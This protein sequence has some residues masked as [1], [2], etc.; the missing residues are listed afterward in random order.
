MSYEFLITSA[1][2]L[3]KTLTRAY[4]HTEKVADER[5]T[6][7]NGHGTNP[8]PAP[9]AAPRS[10]ALDQELAVRRQP[11]GQASACRNRRHGSGSSLSDRGAQRQRV[12][13]ANLFLVVSP[14]CPCLSYL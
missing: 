7:G 2:L 11:R 4:E 3:T 5:P 10:S 9:H 12:H 8:V 13:G 1:Q 6:T 14:L